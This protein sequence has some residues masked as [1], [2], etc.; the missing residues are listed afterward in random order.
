M[1]MEIKPRIIIIDDEADLVANIVD[2]MEDRGYEVEVAYDGKS[3]ITICNEK[4]I[5]VALIDIKLPDMLG[6]DV[7]AKIADLSPMT[8]CI[9]ITGY[10]SLESAV[11][12]VKQN[13]VAAYELKPLEIDRIIALI[14]EIFKRKQAEKALAESEK[15][16]RDM[17]ALIPDI[18]Y[19][20]DTSLN[21]TYVNCAFF[22]VFGYT[23]N[24]LIP[25]INLSEIIFDQDFERAKA[26]LQ[27]RKTG[28]FDGPHEYIFRKKDGSQIICEGSS[29]AIMS[30]DGTIAGFCGVMRDI[31]WRKEIEA[32][33]KM[34]EDQLQHR[35]KIEAIGTLAGGIA[36]DFNNILAVIF[37]YTGMA[38][39]N[40][41]KGSQL[42]NDLEEILTAANR[43]KELVNH[44]L[45]FSRQS[46]TERFPLKIQSIVKESLKMLRASI[47]TTISIKQNIDS[48][49]G[50]ILAD[51]THI[52]Q[53]I[54]NLCT[55]AYHAM[56]EQGGTLYVS[57]KIIFIRTDDCS[58][59]ISLSPG[60][61]VELMVSD[62]GCGI[63]HDIINKVFDPYFTTKNAGKGGTGMGLSV[64]HGIISNYGGA[65]TVDSQV[66]KGTKFY[67]YLPVM[68]EVTLH[69]VTELEDIPKGKEWIL[70]ID[71]E[72]SI[73]QM[74]K[75]ML[76]SLGY[77]VTVSHISFEA[78]ETFQNNP[79]EF[80]LVITDQT[81]SGITGLDLADRILKIRPKIP[82]ILC[83][84]YSK[85][86]DEDSTK[87]HGIK[88]FVLK[89]FT[90]ETIAKLIRKVLDTS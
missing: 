1:E 64:I 88:G 19:E 81:M 47:P 73:T 57:L 4:K 24:E 18:I 45:A 60:E 32:K 17:A 48:N 56:E 23:E 33:N 30:D 63:E 41:P 53:I 27:R 12:A 10:A 21:L 66:G 71:D 44:I 38:K 37:G 68:P 67:V 39:E 28:I 79:D 89:P 8:E 61:Y 83:S 54:I 78:L 58:Y 43:A 80:D 9:L 7:A 35:H 65:I 70:F 42:L 46:K 6:N 86:V 59:P 3:G 84:G 82:I 74:S 76:E 25:G 29:V 87:A 49:S 85:F 50:I 51:P 55:N 90:K 22:N 36:H 31:T 72:E 34:L 15:R 40:A 77:S 69:K 14:N 52:H 16:F 75:N 26:A 5:D 13:G 62:T 11:N 2:I 20:L